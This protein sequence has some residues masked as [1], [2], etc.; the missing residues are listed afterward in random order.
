MKND[1][2]IIRL[3]NKNNDIFEKVVDWN[4]NWWGKDSGKSVEEVRCSMEHSVNTER[5]P[6]TFVA[7]LDGVPCGMYQ[8]SM[9]DDLRGRPDIYPWLINVYVDENY[10]GRDICRKLMETVKEK[11]KNAG[12][13]ELYL[14]TH[15]VGLY[16]KFG[17]EFD[18]DVRTFVEE[19]PIERLYK[20]NL[21]D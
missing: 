13:T 6:Q 20:M 14:Y 17:W 10:R 8:L 11:A 5:L 15:H 2:Q 3:E 4:Y 21:E 19:S 1:L 7:L 9:S 12:L 18:G 16:E